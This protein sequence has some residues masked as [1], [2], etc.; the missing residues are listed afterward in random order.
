MLDKGNIMKKIYVKRLT[1]NAFMPE[2]GSDLAAG[3]D[4]KAM[5]DFRLE[6]HS[7]LL[8]KIGIAVCL[9]ENYYGRIAP[10]SGL[11]NKYGIDVLAGVIDEDYRGEVGVIL[12][13]TSENTVDFKRGDRIAQMI[14]ESY[15]RGNIEEVSDLS[16]TKRGEGGFGST[17]N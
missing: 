12:Y 9:P 3:M 6:A 1:E 7:R 2:Y 4:L 10:R 16:D 14:L 8:V 15:S 11:A 13:N 5:H 17:G